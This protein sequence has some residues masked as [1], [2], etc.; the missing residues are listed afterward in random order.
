[1]IARRKVE[2]SRSVFTAICQPYLDKPF[3]QKL[4]R[5]KVK[6]DDEW[7]SA[8]KIFMGGMT[9]YIVNSMPSPDYKACEVEE[10][11]LAFNGRFGFV[12]EVNGQVQR[13][14]LVDGIE[15]QKGE[16]AV[17][18]SPSF[19]GEVKDVHRNRAGDKE[20][21]FITSAE[22]PEGKTLRG[23]TMLFICGDGGT[24][25]YEIDRV[26]RKDSNSLIYVTEDP[27]I[28]IEGETAK[29]LYFPQR[30]TKGICTFMVPNVVCLERLEEGRYRLTT[31]S[32]AEVS[33]PTS[34]KE[35]S[36]SH[37]FYVNAGGEEVLAESLEGDKRSIRGRVRVDLT[38]GGRTALILR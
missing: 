8:V 1:V 9:D 27:G 12:R 35:R 20:D 7:A 23:R 11:D 33:L 29:R 14:Y 31:T 19:R 6:G 28:E 32:S 17:R 3:V 16:V 38:D 4:E 18:T 24:R 34:S 5:L 37:L 15:F 22:L 2:G 21:C 10:E 36:Y 30:E 26:E 13:L 25:G